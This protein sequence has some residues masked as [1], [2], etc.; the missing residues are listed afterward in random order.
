MTV[1]VSLSRRIMDQECLGRLIQAQS[2]HIMDQECL[3]R[4]IQA[5]SRRIM[6]QECLGRPTQAQSHR[7]IV[8]TVLRPN[9][10]APTIQFI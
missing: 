8:S 9:L 10:T 2:H 3:G 4:L 5:Q 7:S 6:D 1:R